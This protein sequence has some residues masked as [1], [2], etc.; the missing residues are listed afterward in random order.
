M[1]ENALKV[2]QLR[3]S[4]ST[5][6]KWETS[7]V[8]EQAYLILHEVQLDD[9]PFVDIHVLPDISDDASLEDVV[10]SALAQIQVHALLIKKTAKQKRMLRKFDEALNSIA[11]G[12][13]VIKRIKLT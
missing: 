10:N 8:A 9:G 4:I 5:D 6:P 3:L 7:V 1:I 12:V 11:Y 2:H 13:S